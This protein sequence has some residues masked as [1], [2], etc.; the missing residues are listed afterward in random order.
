M[1]TDS[2]TEKDKLGQLI[3]KTGRLTPV[4]LMKAEK[5]RRSIWPW[6]LAQKNR[7]FGEILLSMGAISRTELKEFLEFQ[8]RHRVL[9]AMGATK[10]KYVFYEETVNRYTLTDI[11]IQI[12]SQDIV[13]EGIKR[14]AT[15]RMLKDFYEKARN[16]WPL[17]LHSEWRKVPISL[18]TRDAYVLTRLEDSR[19]IDDVIKSSSLTEDETIRALFALFC[20]GVLNIPSQSR[21][22][23][24]ELDKLE[25]SHLVWNEI[26][27]PE[28]ER[29]NFQVITPPLQDLPLLQEPF[30][31]LSNAFRL[32]WANLKT[33]YE[34]EG[35][36]VFCITSSDM[37]EG[38]SFIACNLALACAENPDYK[39]L[40]M[41]GDLHHPTVHE[42]LNLHYSPGLSD[43]LED[44][45]KELPSLPQPR[46]YKY[47]RLHVLTSGSPVPN[48]V[49]LLGTAA[50]K[51][52]LEK[53]KE[54]F[55]III[56]D[57]PPYLPI[58]DTKVLTEAAD[59]TLI[60]VR[61]NSSKLPDLKKVMVELNPAN[62]IGFIYNNKRMPNKEKRY[63]SYYY[64]R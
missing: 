36:Q 9:S 55:Q 18:S 32:L 61:E 38:K 11:P 21:E 43:Y 47:N 33:M 49:E 7:K 57:T 52:L 3:L 54:E 37:Q 53:L 41:D 8:T 25:K 56:L 26:T 48:P 16:S 13:F 6:R 27:T 50:M 23:F 22:T 20:C 14:H 59:G 45:L 44:A 17:G 24:L 31:Q 30:S 2:T 34:A 29:S 58:V 28:E 60:V 5:K 10:G 51:D 39:I 19:G 1:F 63:G 15:P 35:M 62:L 12:N 46:I 64:H 42:L 4:E 40:L